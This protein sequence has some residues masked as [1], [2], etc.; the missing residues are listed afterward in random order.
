MYKHIPINLQENPHIRNALIKHDKSQFPP[1]KHVIKILKTKNLN[2]F[3]H[4]DISQGLNNALE[5]HFHGVKLK[6]NRFKLMS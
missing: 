5:K 4:K 2:L 1:E 3:N 6:K